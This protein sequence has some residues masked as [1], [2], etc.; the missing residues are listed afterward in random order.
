LGRIQTVCDR[1]SL[2]VPQIDLMGKVAV[3]KRDTEVCTSVVM[4]LCLILGARLDKLVVKSNNVV[5]VK[6]AGNELCSRWTTWK[7]LDQRYQL[8]H[9][10]LKYVLAAREVAG[11]GNCNN[12]TLACDAHDG[13]GKKL[14]NTVIVFNGNVAVMAPPQ[15]RHGPVGTLC[16][17]WIA[18]P[19]PDPVRVCRR[20][21][22]V[23][24]HPSLTGAR[25]FVS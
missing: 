8:E 2:K 1:D 25:F 12:I 13:C 24:N 21:P 3:Q 4:Q 14:F 17:L 15:A 22:L 10:I 16:L 11:H 23:R 6:G 7:D 9:A 19:R 20:F 18:P 5:K